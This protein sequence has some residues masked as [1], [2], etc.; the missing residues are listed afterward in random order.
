MKTKK[1][2]RIDSLTIRMT[3][4]DVSGGLARFGKKIKEE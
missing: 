3:K 4:W 1:N 2:I